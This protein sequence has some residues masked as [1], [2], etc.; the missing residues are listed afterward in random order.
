MGFKR[1]LSCANARAL[2]A[3]VAAALVFSQPIMAA[4]LDTARV[5][6]TG[7]IPPTCAFTTTPTTTSLGDLVTGTQTSLGSFG[8]TCNLQA[9]GSV[10]L[11]VQSQ[12]GALMRDGGTE[13]VEY[14]VIWN[15]QN[16]PVASGDAAAWFAPFAFTLLSGSNGAEQVGTYAVKIVGPT[17]GLVA[18]EYKDTITYTISP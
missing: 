18:G 3:L 13:T 8:F 6:I 4:T 15:I 14:Q 9:A 5:D 2:E 12:N 10:H 11:T 17:Q 7:T 16:N 1:Q